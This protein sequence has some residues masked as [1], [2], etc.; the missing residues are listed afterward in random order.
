MDWNWH[1]HLGDRRIERIIHLAG[2]TLK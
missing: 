2:E 1:Y